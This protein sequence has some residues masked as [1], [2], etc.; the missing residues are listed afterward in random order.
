MLRE[1]AVRRAT[2]EKMMC[3]VKKRKLRCFLRKE[4]KHHKGKF[5]NL[6]N[7]NKI[8]RKKPCLL[9][10]FYP[11]NSSIAKTKEILGNKKAPTKDA[12]KVFQLKP[13]IIN[14]KQASAMKTQNSSRC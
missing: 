9:M 14:F 10:V 3:G 12:I 5:I 13:Y 6:D 4:K 2:H 8:R 1:A 7:R 11:D